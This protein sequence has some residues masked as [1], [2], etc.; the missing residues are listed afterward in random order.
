MALALS[1]ADGIPPVAI[2]FALERFFVRGI[3]AGAVE[4]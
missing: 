2:F 1:N 3:V 4:G